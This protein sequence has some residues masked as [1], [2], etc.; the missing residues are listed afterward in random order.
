MWI[1]L[2]DKRLII[3]GLTLLGAL[4]FNHWQS[5]KKPDVTGYPPAI[6][7]DSE[8]CHRDHYDQAYRE[9][10]VTNHGSADK[11]VIRFWKNKRLKEIAIKA[12]NKCEGGCSSLSSEV[13][14]WDELVRQIGEDPVCDGALACNG[15]EQGGDCADSEQCIPVNVTGGIWQE[16]SKTDCDNA[17]AY[18]HME[19][20]HGEAECLAAYE[21][22]RDPEGWQFGPE[23]PCTNNGENFAELPRAMRS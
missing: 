13:K 15:E 19:F 1:K 2:I 8:E 6:R 16:V 7:S 14:E 5:T 20:F 21:E 10:L 18:E 9:S 3:V 17:F 12:I 11:H 22:W 23:I 4:G